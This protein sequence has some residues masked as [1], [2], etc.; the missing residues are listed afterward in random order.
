MKIVSTTNEPLK[1]RAIKLQTYKCD[2][3]DWQ[4]TL[5]LFCHSHYGD[6]YRFE[7]RRV[8]DR[9]EGMQMEES[10]ALRNLINTQIQEDETFFTIELT[11]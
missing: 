7:T 4:F 10:V 9:L 5:D 6:L 3:A 11:L 1:G 8:L 2:Y